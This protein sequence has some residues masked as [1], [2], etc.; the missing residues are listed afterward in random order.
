MIFLLS[1][2]FGRVISKEYYYNK[3]LNS[4]TYFYSTDSKSTQSRIIGT[5][6]DPLNF[7][8]ESIHWGAIPNS[9]EMSKV[10]EQWKTLYSND[11]DNPK[12]PIS[13]Y[14]PPLNYFQVGYN[15]PVVDW[16]SLTKE[17]QR[18]NINQSIPDMAGIYIY[19]LLF[20]PHRIYVAPTV[21]L[22]NGFQRD[23]RKIR[24]GSNDS[25]LF[26][27][28]VR[29]YGWE[30]F[31]YGQ[32]KLIP[33]GISK[34]DLHNLLHDREDIYFNLL[35][36]LYNWNKDSFAIPS[37]TPSEEERLARSL[38]M[39]GKSVTKGTVTSSISRRLVSENNRSMVRATAKAGVTVMVYDREGN[40]ITPPS[41]CIKAEAGKFFNLHYTNLT[42]YSIPG[43][44][45]NGKYRLEFIKP[46]PVE[47]IISN[48]LP[49]GDAAIALGKPDP[50]AKMVIVV[51]TIT[52]TEFKFGSISNVA[53]W[54]QTTR[55]T[56]RN[57]IKT[58]WLV[59]NR[60]LLKYE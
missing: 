27:R 15:I 25:P 41:P 11:R 44:W 29:A 56:V 10:V 58:K 5:L 43:N 36:P 45:L 22:Y 49:T 21:N 12:A 54:L 55:A 1:N 60:Y 37:H 3:L 14:W 24:E 16:Y 50:R 26:Y 59:G 51:D 6:Y 35:N 57:Y 4:T 52:N 48:S 23:I 19:Q 47:L 30:A 17:G 2:P 31:R 8:T 28:A 34:L 38:S 32:L 40:L 18:L 9:Q 20:N 53:S 39:R 33:I 7:K 42:K 13:L 46:E